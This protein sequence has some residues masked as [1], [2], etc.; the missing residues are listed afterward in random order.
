[1]IGLVS[2]AAQDPLASDPWD[3]ESWRL[4]DWFE[5]AGPFA[6]AFVLAILLARAFARRRRHDIR[7]VMGDGAQ[8]LVHAAITEVEKRTIGE[9]VPVVLGRSDRHPGA[10]WMSGLVLLLVGTA[11]LEGVLP[12][13]APGYLILCQ[14]GLGLAGWLLSRRVPAWKR[15][16]VSEARAS[17]VAAEQ[18]VQ[19]FHRLELAGTAQRT[20]VL[21]FVSLLERRVIVMG[22]VGIDARVEPREWE[23]TRDLVLSGIARGSLAEGLVE[24]VRAAGHVLHAHFPAGEGDRNEVPDRMI[25]RAE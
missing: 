23:R 15:M 17:E 11:L 5:Q 8:Q 22:D 2:S 14:L 3:A 25:V 19:E 20:G 21:L 4:L 7:A 18:A 6:L 13:H 9:I 12:W 16:F 24:G 1:M 10:D